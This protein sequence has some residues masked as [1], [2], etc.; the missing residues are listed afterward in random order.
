MGLLRYKYVTLAEQ[1]ALLLGEAS[2]SVSYTSR[3]NILKTVTKDPRK[4]KAMLRENENIL[5]E[6]ETHLF[7]KKF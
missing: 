7:G 6:N 2:L 5:K 1:V 4:A 3:F